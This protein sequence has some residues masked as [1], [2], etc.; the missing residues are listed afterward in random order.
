M[1]QTAARCPPAPRSPA[2]ER[3]EAPRAHPDR[4]SL[5]RTLALA[6]TLAAPL[7]LRTFGV[8]AMPLDEPSSVLRLTTYGVA[9]S[10]HGAVLVVLGALALGP[11]ARWLESAR[12]FVAELDGKASGR[13]VLALG[14][15]AMGALWR[16]P[17]LDADGPVHWLPFT[18][19]LSTDEGVWSFFATELAAGRNPIHGR[20]F[21][22][23]AV[24]LP[25]T[26]LQAAAAWLF[27]QSVWSIR[28]VNATLGAALA[29]AA[30]LALRRWLSPGAALAGAAALGGSCF[31]VAY[32]RQAFVD[33]TLAAAAVATFLVFA[34]GR[35]GAARGFALGALLVT[36]IAIKI[37]G[38][39]VVAGAVVG[40]AAAA[41]DRE[42]RPS[43]S[44]WLGLAGGLVVASTLLAVP[45]VLEPDLARK[46]IE[47]VI[48]NPGSSSDSVVRVLVRLLEVLRRE[49]LF[50]HMPATALLGYTAL[51]AAVVGL[52]ATRRIDP[53]VAFLVAWAA[54]T[55]GMLALHG[56]IPP[57]YQLGKAAALILLAAWGLDRLGRSLRPG[58]FLGPALASVV[59][60]DLLITAGQSAWWMTH[61]R[62]DQRD[63][64][65]AIAAAL[66][67]GATDAVVAGP[68]AFN[69]AVSGGFRAVAFRPVELPTPR[70]L[71]PLEA[72]AEGA[73]YFLRNAHYPRQMELPPDGVAGGPLLS[74][75]YFCVSPEFPNL[76]LYRLTPRP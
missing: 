12:A 76:E 67:P 62:Y 53:R 64:G 46:A 14:L 69:L 13:V 15:F 37:S 71:Q 73:Q 54:A 68:W 45:Y 17:F 5:A 43:R 60:A 56:Y 7:A 57:R 25:Y 65:R 2:P 11:G 50:V 27:G 36:V 75:C 48:V 28:I 19:D 26:A 52:A 61:R 33:A 55:H 70:G 72:A 1:A 63:G 51:A 9:L 4:A 10:L 58:A 44:G 22:N 40:L 35:L 66:G 47:T 49:P 16:W 59:V 8:L 23:G 31:L 41:F 30:Y 42:R 18:S 24:S 34:S 32:Q 39:P 20:D 6:A 21:I 74:L 38:A 3:D 29:P